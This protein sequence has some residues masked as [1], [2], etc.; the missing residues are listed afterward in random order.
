M[1]PIEHQLNFKYGGINGALG[2]PA[3][4]HQQHQSGKSTKVGEIPGEDRQLSPHSQEHAT[5]AVPEASPPAG[6]TTT[7]DVSLRPGGTTGL[8]LHQAALPRHRTGLTERAPTDNP[9]VNPIPAATG[10]DWSAT[11]PEAKVEG[12]VEDEFERQNDQ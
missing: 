4:A 11:Q 7:P 2:L 1:D 8:S 6:G 3:E 5:P 10:E 9:N 12:Q